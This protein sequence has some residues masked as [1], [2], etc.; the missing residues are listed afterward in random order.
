MMLKQHNHFLKHYLLSIANVHYIGI[1]SY[2]S[3]PSGTYWNNRP[4]KI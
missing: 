1:Y 3:N 4:R 2:V